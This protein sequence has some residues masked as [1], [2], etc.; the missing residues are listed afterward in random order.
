M[1]LLA[2]P[3][4][5]GH[6]ANEAMS[7]FF[8]DTLA[9][10]MAEAHTY[11]VLP[12]LRD[13]WHRLQLWIF[14][15]FGNNCN[16]PTHTKPTLLPQLIPMARGKARHNNQPFMW[17]IKLLLGSRF[18]TPPGTDEIN[19]YNCHPPGIHDIAHHTIPWRPTC[20]VP[21]TGPNLFAHTAHG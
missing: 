5:W 21:V 20:L 18:R 13:I 6:M 2:T 10:I 9:T 7:Y 8:K 4:L 15:S 12:S 17:G 14:H 19:Q 3:S 16:F 1:V 11:L